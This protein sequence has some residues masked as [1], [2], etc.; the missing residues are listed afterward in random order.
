MDGSPLDAHVPRYAV[1]PIKYDD[2][3][4]VLPL[5]SSVYIADFGNSFRARKS[6]P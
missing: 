3:E 2:G 4:S 1:A 5:D 6:Q